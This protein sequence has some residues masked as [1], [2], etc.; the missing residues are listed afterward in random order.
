MRRRDRH[1][2]L[3]LVGMVV[4]NVIISAC[5]VGSVYLQRRRFKVLAD[6]LS[7][8]VS[9]AEKSSVEAAST[10]LLF[11][12]MLREKSPE[13]TGS[14][15]VSTPPRI[16]GYGQTKT[17]RSILVYRDVEQDGVVHREFIQRIPR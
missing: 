4:L 6:A 16:I 1:I 8:R 3:V 7:E 5:S 17:A 12:D 9:A 15:D 11:A 14:S 13:M 10:A 2:N